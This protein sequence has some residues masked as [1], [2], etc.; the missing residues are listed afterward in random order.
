MSDTTAIVINV[1]YLLVAYGILRL[2]KLPFIRFGTWTSSW[3]TL[4]L[5][6]VFFTIGLLVFDVPF[7]FFGGNNP[8]STQRLKEDWWAFPLTFLVAFLISLT[9]K[10]LIEHSRKKRG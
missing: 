6:S 5:G 1:L 2:L 7:A 9:M 3:A 4:F 10:T 8:Y